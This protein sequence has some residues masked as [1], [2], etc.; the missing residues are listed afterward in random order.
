MSRGIPLKWA[1]YGLVVLLVLAPMLILYPWLWDKARSLMLDRA[2]AEEQRF[3]Q[4]VKH[5]VDHEYKR[6]VT[7]LEN[8][9]D[10]IAFLSSGSPDSDLIHRHLEAVLARE[11]AVRGL[12]VVDPEGQILEGIYRG[13]AG[14]PLRMDTHLGGSPL[15]PNQPE[16]AIPLHGRVFVGSPIDHRGELVF[17][18]AIP[19]GPPAQPIASFLAHISAEWLWRELY[20]EFARPDAIT[21][22]VDNR[23]CLLAYPEGYDQPLGELLTHLDIVRSTIEH[24]E[25]NSRTTYLG[26]KGVSCFGSATPID[27]MNWGVITE[28][29][30]RR[31]TE[32]INAVL[33]GMA[34]TT[35]GFGALLGVLGLWIVRRTTRP[36]TELTAAFGRAR[37]GDY[38]EALPLS[39]V[40]E[41]NTLSDGFRAMISNIQS[42]EES[43]QESEERFSKAFMS[44]PQ[45][46]IISRLDDG[47]IVDVNV[48]FERMASHS[49]AKMIGRTTDELGLWER[50]SDRE[51][52]VRAIRE[53]GSVRDMEAAFRSKSGERRIGRVSAERIDIG[54]VPH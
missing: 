44:S 51:D 26:L 32:P 22:L 14:Q 43:L 17:R 6:I 29:P 47:C 4:D 2:L 27:S 36:F 13:P 40:R 1:W 9:G 30:V 23:G 19:V 38:S 50:P 54:G 46:V 28:I 48:S 52:M 33:G 24:E 31:I 18:V 3:N 45:A 39:R 11:E 53:H 34:A 8:K 5:H 7:L 25:W 10:S 35:L 16:I 42:R 37:G 15:D 21:Y 49:R 20:D 41:F 12:A